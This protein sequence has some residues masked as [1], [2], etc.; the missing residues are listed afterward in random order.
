LRRNPGERG[1]NLELHAFTLRRCVRLS[2]SFLAM[3]LGCA[4]GSW[5]FENP[6]PKRELGN[7]QEPKL[8]VHE[9][10]EQVFRKSPCLAGLGVPFGSAKHQLGLRMGCPL[11]DIT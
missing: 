9:N 4:L 2:F 7:E 1:H 3:L 10:H 6:I 8:I 11:L 5:S